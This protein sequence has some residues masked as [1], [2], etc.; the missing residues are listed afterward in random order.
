MNTTD[1][2][3]RLADRYAG[4]VVHDIC[5]LGDTEAGARAALRTAI[6]EV[7]SENTRYACFV[8]QA[9]TTLG[10]QP[11]RGKDVALMVS[12]MKAMGAPQADIEA[13]CGALDAAIRNTA[14]RQT[15]EQEG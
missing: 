13:A 6:E 1:E 11:I 2:L 8:Y 14:M 9:I 15:P 3:M 7:V 4:A 12:L 10:F 5:D